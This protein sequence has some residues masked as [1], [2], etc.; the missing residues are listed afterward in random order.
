M[1]SQKIKEIL[2]RCAK[3]N[4]KLSKTKKPV[5]RLLNFG[6][7]GIELDLVFWADQSLYI[8]ILKSEVRFEIYKELQKEGIT[9]NR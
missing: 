4:P 1:I 5:V 9:G 6:H 8:E 3:E 2:L 7:D